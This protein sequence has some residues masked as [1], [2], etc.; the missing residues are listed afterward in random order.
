MGRRRSDGSLEFMGR[1]D[2]QVKIRG[3]RI[4]LGEI[5]TALAQHHLVKKAVVL[6]RDDGPAGPYLVGYLLTSRDTSVSPEELRSFLS[7]RLPA[8]M[9]PSA[10]VELDAFPLTPNGKIDRQALPLPDAAREKL[11]MSFVGPRTPTEAAIAA[12]WQ[13]VLKLDR[14]GIH[15][16][17]FELGGHSLLATR[18]VSRVRQ[19]FQLDLKLMDL[20]KMPTIAELTKGLE[21]LLWVNAGKP[22]EDEAE[23]QA[24]E[25][26]VV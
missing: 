21:G 3:Y 4:E 15:D 25:E 17:F 24:R 18:V 13:E 6:H 12:I 8:Y 2:T 7:E 9:V 1:K 10:W 20:F 16:N 19:E 23:L 5:E 26:G 14:V 22:S 11:D